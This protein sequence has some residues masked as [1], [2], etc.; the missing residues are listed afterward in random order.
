MML[1]AKAPLNHLI[2]NMQVREPEHHFSWNV[3]S[4]IWFLV[5]YT[6]GIYVYLMRGFVPW[7]A[8]AGELNLAD[9]WLLAPLFLLLVTLLLPRWDA[10]FIMLTITSLAV[11]L[12]L[13]PAA[14]IFLSFYW[15][16][17]LTALMFQIA[18]E[19]ERAIILRLGKFKQVKGPGIFLVLPFIDVVIKKVDL[20][21]RVTDFAAETTLTRDSVPVTV[22]ALCFWLVWD[23]EKAILEVENYTMSKR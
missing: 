4:L 14:W 5:F 19:W 13:G 12:P 11:A 1:T 20:R 8:V 17:G 23:A 3:V 21:I 18:K 6:A 9:L 7:Y 10:A 2:K 22:D 16:G 15:M